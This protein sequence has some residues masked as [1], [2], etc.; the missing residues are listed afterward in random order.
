M[1]SMDD[2]AQIAIRRW[3]DPAAERVV[4][5]HGNGLAIDAFA[6]FGAELCRRFEVIAFDMRNHGRNPQAT[7][8]QGNWPRFIADFA[9]ILEAAD[10]AFGAKPTHGAFHSLSSA[11]CLLS[12]TQDAYPWQ[13][14]TLFEPPMPADAGSPLHKPFIDYHVA[15]SE[16]AARRR[17]SFDQPADLAGSMRRSSLFSLVGDED[18]ERLARATLRE[19]ADGSWQL[20]C[21]PEFEAETF[22]IE[23]VEHL[24][25]GLAKVSCPVR[26][27]LGERDIHYA[28]ILVDIGRE[29]AADFG[30]E[31]IELKRATHFMQLEAPE[32]CASLVGGGEFEI[33]NAPG[34]ANA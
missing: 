5:S 28:A 10:N 8:A 6:R 4:I 16:R 21:P 25:P 18:I 23:A 33:G 2:G 17:E 7:A 32:T 29:L 34:N 31:C 11:V 22:R 14:L 26:L 13:S 9:Q 3:G 24:R 15:L 12:L 30:F 1:A 27:V 20:C 19:R